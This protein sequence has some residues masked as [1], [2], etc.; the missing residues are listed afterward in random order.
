MRSVTKRS[1]PLVL[2]VRSLTGFGGGPEKTILNSPRFLVELGYDTVCAYMHPPADPG[3]EQLRQ[4][5]VAAA[6][7]IL[8]VPDR[9]PWDWRVLTQ[10]IHFCRE[11]RVA[12]WHAHDYKSNA[13]GLIARC[14]WPMKL[15]TTVHGWVQHTRRTP[16]YYA[17]DRRCLP[18]YQQVV[19]VSQDLHHAALHCGVPASRCHWIPNAIDLD[20]FRR[21]AEARSAQRGERPLILGAM[22]RLSPEKGFDLLIRAVA[23]L[24]D[25]GLACKLRIAG[26]G[27]QRVALQQQLLGLNCSASVELLG[28]VAD[29]RSFYADLDMFV[30]SS[31]REGLPNVLLEAMALEVPVLSTR[32]AGIPQLIR[33]GE[34][35]MLIAPES[36]AELKRGIR[37]L[38]EQ[39]CLC[40]HL[41]AAGRRLVEQ[42]FSF[43][44][45][46][47]RIAALYDGLLERTPAIC[48]TPTVHI[49]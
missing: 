24:N 27:E 47:E 35:G 11:Q 6:A 15:V 32:V 30:L 17:I 40:R 44:R 23:E 10:L 5:A 28:Q 16:L 37:D 19:C 41:A 39:P 26:E 45:R 25:A 29:V 12:I 36:V 49:P 43:R 33:H 8:S 38:A 42:S 4:R 46:M 21:P 3:M 9:G 20:E 1:S 13:L 22:G 7:H 2:H 18:Y 34:N 31:R 14:F 48:S